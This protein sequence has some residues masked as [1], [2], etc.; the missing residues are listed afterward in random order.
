MQVKL[1]LFTFNLNGRLHA[2]SMGK[3]CEQ[4]S[5]LW[6]VR[7]LKTESEPNFG[8][9][10]ISTPYWGLRSC[11]SNDRNKFQNSFR[12]FWHYKLQ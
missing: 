1:L 10:H 5:N 3:P 6:M 9:L 4:M 8:F 11:H 12:T 7:F 2:V